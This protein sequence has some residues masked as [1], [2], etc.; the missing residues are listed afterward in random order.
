MVQKCHF[1]YFLGFITFAMLSCTSTDRVIKDSEAVVNAIVV[2]TGGGFTGRA[3]CYMLT[4]RGMLYEKRGDEYSFLARMNHSFVKQVFSAY[5]IQGFSEMSVHEPGNKFYSIERRFEG[6]RHQL[7]WGKNPESPDILYRYHR[8]I[9]QE[10][11][12][13]VVVK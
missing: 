3:T 8:F 11:K 7:M 5:E 12:K 13:H 10:I 2:T 1:V 6:Q 4:E 9:W